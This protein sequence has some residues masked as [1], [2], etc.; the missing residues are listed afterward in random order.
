[1]HSTPADI[2]NVAIVM[3]NAALLAWLHMRQK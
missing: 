3:V 2:V 1:V